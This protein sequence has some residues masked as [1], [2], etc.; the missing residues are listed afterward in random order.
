MYRYFFYQIFYKIFVVNDKNILYN[1]LQNNYNNNKKT[2]FMNPHLKRF[3]F[4]S[5]KRRIYENKKQ[6]NDNNIT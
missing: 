6:K 1:I 2:T 5:L 3:L 4:I